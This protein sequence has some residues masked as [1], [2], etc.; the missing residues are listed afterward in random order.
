MMNKELHRQ[1][2][3]KAVAKYH[4]EKV[5]NLTIRVPKGRRAYYKAC[6][7]AAGESLNALAVRALDELIEREGIQ[8][9]ADLDL[10]EADPAAVPEIQ[11]DKESSGAE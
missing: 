1:Q 8:P 11:E 2:V 5:E 4:R 10:D 7:A 6:A 9:A 3:N